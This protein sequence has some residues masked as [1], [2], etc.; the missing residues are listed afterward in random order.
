[1][2][3]DRG[4]GIAGAHGIHHVLILA[5]GYGER[6][7]LAPGE[8][9]A[10]RTPRDKQVRHVLAVEEAPGR[11]L[12]LRRRGCI[13]AGHR[14]QFGVAQLDPV[15]AVEAPSHQCRRPPW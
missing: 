3:H 14:G 5:A 7:T 15:G 1:M 2:T 10:S 11:N 6:V 8:E 9:G 4:E 12:A 13:H